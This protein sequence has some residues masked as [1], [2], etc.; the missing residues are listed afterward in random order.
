MND[1]TDAQLLQAYAARHSEPAFAELVRRH[2]DFVHSAAMRMVCDSHLA[3]DVSQA[4]FAALARNAFQLKDCHVLPGW[5]HQTAQNIAA[6]T[7]RTDVRRRARE[8]EAAA[9]NDLL[10]SAQDVNW[11][12]IAPHLDAA[13]GELNGPDRDAVLLRYFK[14]QDLRTVGATLGIS[15]DAAQKRVGRALEKLRVYF[16]KRGMAL[17]AAALTAAISANAVQAA[18]VGLAITISTATALAGTTLATATTATAIKTITM[19]TIQKVVI[20][21]TLAVVAGAGIFEA[22]QASQLREQVHTLRQQQET[23]TEQIRNLEKSYDDATNQLALLHDDNER[24]NRNTGELLKL[25]SEVSR[26]RTTAEEL[27]RARYGI[28]IKTNEGLGGTADAWAKRANSFKQ[29]FEQNPDKSIPELQLLTDADWLFEASLN[30][31]LVTNRSEGNDIHMVADSL[32]QKAKQKFANLLGH[33]LGNYIASNEGSLPSELSQLLVYFSPPGD[34]S[35]F[36]RSIDP[37]ILQRYDLLH[38]G[39]IKDVPQGDA[40]IR[41]KAPVDDD[42]DGILSVAV[43]SHSMQSTGKIIDEMRQGQPSGWLDEDIKKIQPFLK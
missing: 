25:R 30:L 42:I 40:I 28:D 19:T 5:L 20:T 11:E 29:W 10:L 9:M 8:Q 32:R 35:P 39:K 6:Q 33:A 41:E 4:T 27:A 26:L 13:I 38:T 3:E 1:Q 34:T 12:H 7:V 36:A 37:S 24:L 2:L 22:R 17:P 15:D 21:A 23:L 31:K 16:S 14:N 18:P 43:G